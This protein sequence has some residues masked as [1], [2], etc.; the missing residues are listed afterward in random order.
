[1]WSGA[2]AI[3]DD[4]STENIVITGFMASGKTTVGRLIASLTERRFVDTDTVIADRAGMSIAQIFELK[5]EAAFRALEQELCRDLAA[6][7]NLVI[8]TGGGMLVNDESRALMLENGFVVCL[9]TPPEL[10]RARLAAATDRPLAGDW[11]ALYAKR[12]AAYAA[13][14]THVDTLDKTPEQLAEEIVARWRS[15][16]R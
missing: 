16:S 15:A 13:I 8:A 6:E 10:I 12:R 11:E 4:S 5:G 3:P 1:M 2:L 14:P 7:R 9:D